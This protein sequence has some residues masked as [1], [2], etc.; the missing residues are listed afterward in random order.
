MTN[1]IAW[2]DNTPVWSEAHRMIVEEIDKL[3]SIELFQYADS[4]LEAVTKNAYD[5]I[6]VEPVLAPGFN[7]PIP[8]PGSGEYGQIGL[9]LVKRIRAEGEN[10][11]TPL[12]VIYKAPRDKNDGRI[13]GDVYEDDF[14]N[15]GANEVI[16]I[17]DCMPDQFSA[18]IK[19]YLQKK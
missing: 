19:P 9:D 13:Y 12:I 2:I 18:K 3:G 4:A 8:I 6:V 14:R 5:L 11:K 1:K 10:I 16:S 7:Y 17:C 15:A